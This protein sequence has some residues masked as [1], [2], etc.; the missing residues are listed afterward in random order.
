MYPPGATEPMTDHPVLDAGVDVVQLEGGV[1]AGPPSDLA[2]ETVGGDHALGADLDLPAH[3]PGLDTDDLALLADDAG[4]GGP[5]HDLGAGLGGVP[6][7]GL[8]EQVPLQHVADLGT[9]LGLVQLEG[10]P[11]GGLDDRS[12]HVSADPH[13]LRLDADLLQPFLGDSLGAPEG[14]SDLGLLLQKDRLQS[15]LGAVPGGHASAGSGPDDDNIAIVCPHVITPSK[16]PPRG[17]A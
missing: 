16:V 2:L 17:T 10:G 13:G 4:A 6:G 8:V 12:L 11:L 7:E 5:H 3:A 15:A 14:R 9:G 1:D